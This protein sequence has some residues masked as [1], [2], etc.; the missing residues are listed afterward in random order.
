M[1]LHQK[2]MD[3]A[4]SKADVKN[5]DYRKFVFGLDFAKRCAV[6]T[7]NLNYQVENGGLV[8]WHD[9][10]YS[11]CTSELL[12][13]LTLINSPASKRVKHVIELA[14]AIFSNPYSGSLSEDDYESLDALD[15]SYYEAQSQFL[16][17][18]EAFL[19]TLS[20]KRE[21]EV[22]KPVFVMHKV[23]G[24]LSL[25]CGETEQGWRHFRKLGET[26]D[27]KKAIPKNDLIYLDD[28][29]TAEI[30]RLV[31]SDLLK[32]CHALLESAEGIGR[33]EKL[34]VVSR[35]AIDAIKKHLSDK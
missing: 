5:F 1:S 25:D 28:R 21:E 15:G 35:D 8:Q 11:S 19:N 27:L 13:V 23:S 33:S 17:D 32:A 24:E 29:G 20:V 30:A 16:L 22:Y 12:H 3:Q 26:D 9:N 6:L 2:L 4:Y 34:A 18:T 14:T 7:G 10:K 31:H